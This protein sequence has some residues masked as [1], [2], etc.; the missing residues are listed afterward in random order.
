LFGA[1]LLTAMNAAAVVKLA[2]E[3]PQ[4]GKRLAALGIVVGLATA[5][6]YSL[7]AIR[8]LSNGTRLKG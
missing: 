7:K 1:V 5:A 8:F 2:T 3:S 4:V 6:A